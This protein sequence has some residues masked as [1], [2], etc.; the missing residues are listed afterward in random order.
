MMIS[1]TAGAACELRGI[2]SLRLRKADGS[3]LDVQDAETNAPALAPVVV[4][5]R[6]KSTAELVFTWQNW[7]GPD[8]GVLVMQIGLSNGAGNL[9]ARLNGKLG[10]Y[11]PTCGRPTAPSVLRVEYAYVPAGAANLASALRRPHEWP[12]DGGTGSGAGGPL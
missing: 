12:A 8:P 2:P 7:C 11:V 3:I 6:D 4:Q 5:P 1:N 10:S 9:V